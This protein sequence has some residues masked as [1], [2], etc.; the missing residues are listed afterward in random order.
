VCVSNLLCVSYGT[1]QCLSA[2]TYDSEFKFLHIESSNIKNSK[3]L[4]KGDV[5]RFDTLHVSN[6]NMV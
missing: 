3:F 4:C 1:E 2:F 6:R 5:P